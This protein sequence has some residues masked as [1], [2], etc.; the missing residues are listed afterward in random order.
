MAGHISPK[1]LYYTIFTAL[2]VLTAITVAVAFVNLGTLNFPIALGIAITKATLV[3]LFFMHLK[4]SSRLTKLVCGSAFFFLLV[5][6]GL[7][8]SDYLSR[9]WHTAPGGVSTGAG[10]R[11]TIGSAS[12]Q[13][14]PGA[15]DAP[16]GA[17][18]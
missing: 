16:A 10:T 15:T 5:L 13:P 9:G 1:R 18:R 14:A 4:Y 6:F 11:V 3:I 8:L 17:G 2:M 7:T 12:A